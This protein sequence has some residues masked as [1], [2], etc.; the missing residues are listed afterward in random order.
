MSKKKNKKNNKTTAS[1]E[2]K[3]ASEE[4]RLNELNAESEC[5]ELVGEDKVAAFEVGV[6]EN[7]E[8]AESSA[9]SQAEKTAE[10]CELM[11]ATAESDSEEQPEKKRDSATD[12]RKYIKIALTLI[13]LFAAVILVLSAVDSL[14]RKNN[15]QNIASARRAAVFAVFADADD[16]ISAES[17]QYIYLAVKEK[18]LLGYCI[19]K[20]L[21]DYADKTFIMV[22]ILPSGEIAGISPFCASGE[23]P[24]DF[25]SVSELFNKLTG[26]SSEKELDD[27][28]KAEASKLAAS[29]IAGVRA[30]LSERLDVADILKRYSL[31]LLPAESDSSSNG[32]TS[33]PPQQSSEPPSES[34]E[35][36]SE[37]ITMEVPT[38]PQE[39]DREIEGGDESYSVVDIIPPRPRDDSVDITNRETSYTDERESASESESESES[40]SESESESETESESESESTTLHPPIQTTAPRPTGTDHYSD[41]IERPDESESESEKPTEPIAPSESETE[42]PLYPPE[43]ETES[44]PESEPESESESEFETESE[45]QPETD[46]ESGADSS[47]GEYSDDETS[48]YESDNISDI[49]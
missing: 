42:E 31:S 49:E 3:I 12:S 13:A 7:E 32:G 6:A 23:T 40:A 26:I 15:G 2:N 16:I 43:S 11:E 25:N 33:N 1:S 18:R 45:T 34:K 41:F 9:M 35:Q 36:G 44:E 22:G 29:V 14:T 37:S 17:D 21:S 30:A 27:L 28:S 8:N 5:D 38:L 10:N 39:S 46:T 20:E 48:Y 24:D 19:A 4:V 47:D